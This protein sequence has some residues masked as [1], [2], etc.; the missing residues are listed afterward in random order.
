MGQKVN[1]DKVFISYS[2][3]DKEWLDRLQIH[4][5]PYERKGIIE[6]WDDTKIKVGS[7]W[8]DEI[9]KALDSAKVA[10]LLVSADFIASDF[11]TENE[12]KPLLVAAKNEGTIILPIIIKPCAYSESELETFQSVNSPSQPLCGMT[13]YEQE[14]VLATGAQRIKKALKESL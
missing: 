1:R 12:L 7:Q 8:K 14:Q 9:K 10:V 6:P 13:D 4:I 3:S 2:H 11:I 5:K